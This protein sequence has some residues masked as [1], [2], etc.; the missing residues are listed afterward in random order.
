[1]MLSQPPVAD[2]GVKQIYSN[3]GPVVAAVMAEQAMDQ[4]WEDLM[5]EMW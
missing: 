2:P 4:P 5:R 3:V 1:M